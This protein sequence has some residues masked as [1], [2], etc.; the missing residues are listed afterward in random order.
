MITQLTETLKSRG[1]TVSVTSDGSALQAV[2]GHRAGLY[3]HVPITDGRVYFA[4]ARIGH[5]SLGQTEAWP[6]NFDL[7]RF[8]DA[9]KAGIQHRHEA[10]AQRLSETQQ[11]L[12]RLA[13]A[14]EGL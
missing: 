2:N 3:I 1:F 13:A 5:V 11:E 12:S 7:S 9:V 14:L 10:A 4:W 8:L 6:R